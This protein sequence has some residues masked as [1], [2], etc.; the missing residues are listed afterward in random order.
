MT[1]ERATEQG[2][3]HLGQCRLHPLALTGG[4]HDDGTE[5]GLG[6]DVAPVGTA[7][8]LAAMLAAQPRAFPAYPHRA[9]KRT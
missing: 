1:E 2:V 3:Q 9:P 4:E 7:D 6:H 8:T 5:V